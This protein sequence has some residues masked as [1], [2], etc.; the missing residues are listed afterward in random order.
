MMADLP[1]RT[2][3]GHAQVWLLYDPEP[4]PFDSDD[5]KAIH[6]WVRRCRVYASRDRAIKVLSDTLGYPIDWQ[7]YN[8]LFP[9]LWVAHDRRGYRWLMEPAAVDPLRAY[10]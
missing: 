2:P 5:Q 1:E 3:D 10:E 6:L 9:E 7:P 4:W 8:P